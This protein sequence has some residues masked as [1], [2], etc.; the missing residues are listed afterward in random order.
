MQ[1]RAILLPPWVKYLKSALNSIRDAG[2]KNLDVVLPMS[3]IRP[4]PLNTPP[5]RLASR[6]T[7]IS[8]P[9]RPCASNRS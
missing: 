4:L 8:G 3:T 9:D 2:W 7:V 5:D 1:T 6:C